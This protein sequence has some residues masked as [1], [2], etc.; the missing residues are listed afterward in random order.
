VIA[1]NAEFIAKAIV[2]LMAGSK[3]EEEE[4]PKN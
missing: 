3:P 1:V 4:S 2:E